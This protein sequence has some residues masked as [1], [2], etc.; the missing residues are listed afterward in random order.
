VQEYGFWVISKHEDILEM[1]KDPYT[2]SSAAGPGGGLVAGEDGE[3]RDDN[4]GMGFLPLIQH[5][6]PEHTRIRS[7]FAKAF[8]PKRIAE[9]EPAVVEIA[10]NLMDE[11]HQK[12][13]NGEA[14]DLVDDFASPLPV[15]VIAQMMGIP[16]EERHRLRMWSDSLAIGAGEGYSIQQQLGSRKEMTEGLSE[17]ISAAR[18]NPQANTLISAMLD[19]SEEGENLRTEEILGLSK[20]L[21]LAGNETTTNLISNGVVFLLN[22]PDVLADLRNDRTLISDF[23]EEMLRYD[24]PVMGL[25]RIATRNVEFRGKNISKGDTL[26]LLF[27]SGNLDADTYE[28]PETFD[29]HR[30]NKDHLALGKG[31]HFCMGSALARLEAK[32]AFEWLID[33][34]PHMK[35]DFENGK[36]IPV[37]ILS[38]WV[39]LPMS[40]D[41]GALEVAS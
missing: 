34:L 28:A 13:R 9:M 22:H 4:G 7:L 20:L 26:W 5:D 29:L 38:G 14:L 40:V 8:T 11:L 37:P 36:R 31:I 35:L 2:Y 6:P 17:I 18:H 39:K 21:W 12:I 41:V 3:Q 10:T 19:A 24:G 15:Y 30:R 23:V 27:S 25:F 33:L 16:L 32:V 1:L